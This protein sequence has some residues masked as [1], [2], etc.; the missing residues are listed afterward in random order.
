MSDADW[1]DEGAQPAPKK[2][3]IPTWAWWTCGG[4]CLVATLIAIALTVL[5][6]GLAKEFGDTEAAWE[7]VR[8][9]LPYDVRPEGWEARGVTV[10]GVSNYFLD[11]PEPGAAVL[12]QSLPGTSEF[13]AMFDPD[14]PN[15]GGPIT[16]SRLRDPV[17]GTLVLQGR[18]VRSLGFRGGLG[19]DADERGGYS[20][21]IDLQR[22]DPPTLVQLSLRHAEAPLTAERVAELLA[23][24]D[25]WRGR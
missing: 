5:A 25:V 4:G 24:F 11:P 16:F 12:V 23:P 8:E 10:F 9:M 2:K 15:N 17:P 13:E 6:V 3:R 7:K 18:E 22:K 14:S 21:R 19:G 20:I 1:G